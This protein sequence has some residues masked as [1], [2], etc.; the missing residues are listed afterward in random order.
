MK[1][2]LMCANGLSTG[3]LMKKMN[4]WAIDR[5]Q[6]LE[7]KAIPVDDYLRVYKEYD[8]LLIGPQMRYKLKEVR[9]MASDRPSAVINPS[10][11]ALGNV[12]NI[13]KEVYKLVEGGK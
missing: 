7:V 6:D 2:L 9:K 13:M 10:D 12:D 5:Q 8:V 4:Q 3:I 1:I 11:Y